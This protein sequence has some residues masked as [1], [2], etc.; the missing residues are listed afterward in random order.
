[1]TRMA[2]T[3]TDQL[4]DVPEAINAWRSIVDE[5]GPDRATLE[6]LEAL[7]EKA[8]RWF[9]LAETFE[10]HLSLAEEPEER[11]ALQ[12]R[13]GDVRRTH[14][15]DLAGALDAYRQ[16]FDSGSRARSQP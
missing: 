11:L 15:N 2:E 16:A 3:L 9:D 6:S 8:E 4:D 13:L 1:M 14:Q 10:T 7:Y 12:V 5:F